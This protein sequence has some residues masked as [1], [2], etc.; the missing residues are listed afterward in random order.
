M[1]THQLSPSQATTSPA[2]MHHSSLDCVRNSAAGLI[3][4]PTSQIGSLTN[5]QLQQCISKLAVQG[6]AQHLHATLTVTA[7][8]NFNTTTVYFCTDC[9]NYHRYISCGSTLPPLPLQEKYNHAGL[10]YKIFNQDFK[11]LL[12]RNYII[13][14]FFL[15]K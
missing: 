15:H 14:F 12:E 1:F 5:R 13:V 4:N 3:S 9:K 10:N 11:H 2:A 7:I 6:M 8:D